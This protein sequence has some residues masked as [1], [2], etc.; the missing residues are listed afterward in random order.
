MN[1]VNLATSYLKMDT[2]EIE[3]GDLEMISVL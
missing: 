1:A 2:S 3:C